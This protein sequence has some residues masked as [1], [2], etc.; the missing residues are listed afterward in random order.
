MT[1]ED[2]KNLQ[3]HIVDRDTG[4]CPKDALHLFAGNVFVNKHNDKILS[5]MPGEK[6]EIPCHHCGLGKDSS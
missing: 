4:N 3:T 5:Q 2:Q 6:V 1:A